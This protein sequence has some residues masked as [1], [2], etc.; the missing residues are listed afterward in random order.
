MLKKWKKMEGKKK[1]KT[2]EGSSPSGDCGIIAITVL[3]IRRKRNGQENGK[4]F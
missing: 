2:K 1:G 4:V 3:H